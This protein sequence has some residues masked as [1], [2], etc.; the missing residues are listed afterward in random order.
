MHRFY[1]ISLILS[2][3]VLGCGEEFT[4]Q[5]T[6][7]AGSGGTAGTGG[8]TGGSAGSGND[9]GAGAGGTAGHGGNTGG[10]AGSTGGTAGTGGAGGDA[11]GNGG[12]GGNP[13]PNTTT[14]A[15]A[16]LLGKPCG[17]LFP[18]CGTSNPVSRA[19]FVGVVIPQIAGS[20]FQGYVEPSV[21]S[22]Q[23]VPV[24]NPAFSAVE[25]AVWLEIIPVTSFFHPADPTTTCFAQEVVDAM[26]GLGSMY[27]VVF[28]NSPSG[29][30]LS[31]ES[32]TTIIQMNVYGTSPGAHLTQAV[33]VVNDLVGD[34]SV[35][36]GTSALEALAISCQV[37][38]GGSN[39]VP[40]T[41]TIANPLT[42]DGVA[43]YS[44]NTLNCYNQAGGPMEL[45]LG[46][47]PRAGGAGQQVRIGLRGLQVRGGQKNSPIKTV[48]NP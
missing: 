28:Y 47:D 24:G 29:N 11:G 42:W 8:N 20:Q 23:D 12:G 32:M 5:P 19:E 36:Q 26:N 16:V 15:I 10:S 14:D 34:F 31:N 17:D 33:Q 3:F 18:T 44:Q 45:L 2:L 35:A 4:S 1:M 6:P 25:R 30:I 13:C 21:A 7:D 43:A 39:Y 46:I 38:A 9:A 40:Y 41:F 27:A 22:F 48:V 37:P